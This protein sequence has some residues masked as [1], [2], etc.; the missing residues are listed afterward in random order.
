MKV[1]IPG[2][3]FSV[4]IFLLFCRTR[5]HTVSVSSFTNERNLQFFQSYIICFIVF[6]FMLFLCMMSWYTKNTKV[7]TKNINAA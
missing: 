6:K 5:K 3:S 7:K 4:A 1:I 2:D